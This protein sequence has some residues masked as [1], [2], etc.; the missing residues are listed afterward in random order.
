MGFVHVGQAGLELLP[1]SDL[2]ASVSQNTLVRTQDPFKGILVFT[3]WWRYTSHSKRAVDSRKETK[4][5]S[6]EGQP[7]TTLRLPQEVG[8]ARTGGHRGLPH[9]FP[10]PVPPRSSPVPGEALVVAAVEEVGLGAHGAHV[11]VHAQELQQ[12]PRAALLHADDDGLRQLLAAF[13]QE[14]RQGPRRGL[15]HAASR[16]GA[17]G[18]PGQARGLLFPGR[19]LAVVARRGRPAPPPLLQ[20]QEPLSPCRRRPHRQLPRASGQDAAT[21]GPRLLAAAGQPHDGAGQGLAALGQAVE[22]V[23]GREQGAEHQQELPKDAAGQ[24]LCRGGEGAGRA[25]GGHPSRRRR[26]PT[27]GPC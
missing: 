4:A 25:R 15:G 14:Q 27:R 10:S 16:P 22:D 26:R 20:L 18:T 8:R 2:P 21:R 11:G 13:V 9:D 3:D 17:A 6:T 24:R 19:L 12:R 1:S 23:Q 5:P 7:L